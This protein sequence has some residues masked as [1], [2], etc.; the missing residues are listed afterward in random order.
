MSGSRA[1]DT[2]A[3]D[4]VVAEALPDAG[5]DFWTDVYEACPPSD[6]TVTAGEL[7]LAVSVWDSTDRPGAAASGP[8]VLLVHGG[9]EQR[10]WWD[11]LVPLVRG[12][13]HSGRGDTRR[14]RVPRGVLA[15]ADGDAEE[16]PKAG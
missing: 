1:A 10:S 12:A 2:T 5:T 15:T 7:T 8:D 6:V 14:D 4:G 13:D 16:C 9:A 11:H 3:L